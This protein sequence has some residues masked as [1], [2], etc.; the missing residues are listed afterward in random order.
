MRNWQ[1]LPEV[2]SNK[3]QN[4][5]LEPIQLACFLVASIAAVCY[6]T[7]L[8]GEFVFDDISS[9]QNNN[10]IMGDS[11]TFKDIFT[12]DFWGAPM[13]DPRSNKSYRPVT[14]LVFRT[15]FNLVGFASWG[16]HFCDVLCHMICSVLMVF[17]ARS[18]FKHL[19]PAFV[20]ATLFAVHPIHTESVA[21]CTGT[22][23]VL[24]AIFSLAA[25]LSYAKLLDTARSGATSWQYFGLAVV[26][27]VLAMLCKETGV[28]IFVIVGAFDLFKSGGPWFFSPYAGA[29][30]YEHLQGTQCLHVPSSMHS[31]TP[32]PFFSASWLAWLKQGG[33]LRVSLLIVS[34]GMILFARFAMNGDSPPTF[35]YFVNPSVHQD[36]LLVQTLTHHYLAAFNAYLL[37]FPLQVKHLQHSYGLTLAH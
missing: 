5:P 34:F 26:L 14:I 28:M 32:L 25:F 18:L 2:V 4:G 10:D 1:L 20:C 9:I 8:A 3:L 35:P 16:F 21:N 11:V 6:V 13:A 27:G 33:G 24:A 19:C 23:D 36:S 15:I 30:K 22:A 31:L 29:R 12:H 37:A 17:F 7:T